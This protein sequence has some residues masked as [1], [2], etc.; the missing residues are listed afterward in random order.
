MRNVELFELYVAKIFDLLYD[1]FPIAKDIDVC[2]LVEKEIDPFELKL[3]KEC[4]IV[5]HT[6]YFLKQEG[7]LCYEYGDVNGFYGVRLTSKAL[8]V[9][10]KKPKSLKTNLIDTIKHWL[11]LGNDELVKK[12]VELIFEGVLGAS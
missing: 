8:A 1:E 5:E 6:F 9:L 2:K 11:K 10:Q 3:P 4:E 7:Y 12:S